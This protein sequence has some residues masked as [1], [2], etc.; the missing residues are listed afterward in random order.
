MFLGLFL[1]HYLDFQSPE[2]DG[3]CSGLL[4]M[5]IHCVRNPGAE[6]EILQPFKVAVQ[7]SNFWENYGDKISG[8]DFILSQNHK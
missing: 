6:I 1:H 3:E 8:F 2:D 4:M 7:L 5:T